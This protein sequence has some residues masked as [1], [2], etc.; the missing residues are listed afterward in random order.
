MTHAD[1]HFE[2]VGGNDIYWQ[3]WLPDGEVRA[4]LVLAHGASEHSGRY[5]WTGEQLNA[6]ERARRKV[7]WSGF[8]SEEGARVRLRLPEALPGAT[9]LWLSSDERAVKVNGVECEAETVER[10]GFAFRSVPLLS[11]STGDFEIEVRA[12]EGGRSGG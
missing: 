5:A 3:T 8:E 11:P 10:W 9:L 12:T 6:W 1:G 2:G 4:A 7:E